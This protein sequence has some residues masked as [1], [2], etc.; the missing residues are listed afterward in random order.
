MLGAYYILSVLL[1]FFWGLW[2]LQVPGGRK[3]N[4]GLKVKYIV[5]VFF[6]SLIPVLNLCCVGFTFFLVAAFVMSEGWDN[7][8]PGD[9]SKKL[10]KFFNHQFL[11]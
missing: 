7:A 1:S 9:R 5:V 8:F 11:K 4:I 10:D 3:E 6:L 2:F